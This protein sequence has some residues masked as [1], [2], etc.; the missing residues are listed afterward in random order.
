MNKQIITFLSS[1]MLLVFV[2]QQGFSQGT[3]RGTVYDDVTGETVPF[4]TVFVIETSG[5]TTTDLDGTYSYDLPAGSYTL[6]FSFIGFASLKVSE[7]EIVDDEV[8]V[9]DIRLKE[10][11]TMLDE[12][13]VTAK[14]IRNTEAAILTLQK[15]SPNLLDGISSQTFKRIGDSNV[16]GAIKRVTGV[17]VEGGK[18]VF[19]R[20]LGDRYTKSILNGMDIPGLDPD[21]NTLQMD[22]F[23]T[24]LI[25]NI[26]VVKSFT[27]DL[28]GDFTGGVVNIVTKDF[29][30]EKTMNI[31]AGLGYNP[32][33][34]LNDN[35][36]GYAGSS[37]DALGFDNGDRRRPLSRNTFIPRTAQQSPE[38]NRLTQKFS[39]NWEA[40]NKRSF[41]DYNLGFSAGNQ[42]DKKK[43]TIGYNMALNYKSTN[44][45]FD[46]V[47]YNIF[48]KPDF[49]DENAFELTPDRKQAGQLSK[50]NVLL[51]GLV[52][53]AAK[54]DN[55]KISLS[56]IRIQNGESKAGEFTR[57]TFISSDNTI[58]R[59]NLE[60]TERA[61]SNAL[62]SGK[63]SF[64]KGNLEVEWKLSP[65]Y[66]QI[67][68]KDIRLA[69]FRV[70]G[71]QFSIEPSEG[72]VPIRI[73]RSLEEVNYSGKMD[74]T[75]KILVGGNESKIKIGGSYVTKNRNYDIQNFQFDVRNADDINFSGDANDL[76]APQN[77]WT[78]E[79][80]TGVFV[81][82]NYEPA[83]TY[84]ADQNTLGAYIMNELP[85]SDKFKAVYGARVEHFQHIYTG[86]NNLGDRVFDNEE[87]INN[88]NILPA[89][90]LIYTL[91]DNMN[92]RASFSRT[93]A[94]PS[95]KEVSLAQIYDALSDRTY[96]GNLDLISTDVNNFDVRWE[97]YQTGGQMFAVSA[98]YKTFENPIEIV[99]FS[100]IAPN[101]ITPRNVG[102]A[103]VA[104]IEI[105]ARKKLSF[106]NP[107]LSF[108]TN[109][110]FVHSEVQMDRSEGGEY[111]SRVR[112]A[113]PGEI[114]KE[115]RQMQGQSPFILNSYV[116]YVLPD[117]GVEANL[118]YNVQGKRLAIVGISQNPDVFEQ[119]FH[120]LNFKFSKAVGPDQKLRLSIAGQNLL[121][122]K[123]RREYES[124][125]ADNQ[126]YES[127]APGRA[128]SISA[129]YRFF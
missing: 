129:S 113:R 100:E 52:G 71:G 88:W 112:N 78:P 22:V 19:V 24:N 111:E 4:A 75:K 36:L 54:W 76:L 94:R 57:N 11:S 31:S 37:T 66:S 89:A 29:P 114:I 53:A 41:V 106:I 62:L 72:A 21:R 20:G 34:H 84:D 83:N 42:F 77:I 80:R 15:K 87:L 60:Y 65:T 47:Q 92:L 126:T 93:L 122:S 49:D 26:V 14:Q 56:A 38:L 1:L 108:G 32:S 10:E 115:T 86:Q 81:T 124:F 51:T 45:Y 27:P 117:S 127:F 116:N 44:Q 104:G 17:S 123:I 39:N 118:S 102:D 3:V 35:A 33:M 85:I 50:N 97:N 58:N 119:P 74:V 25:D 70:D 16:A 61:I 40:Q 63:H 99:A 110:T 6:E 120:S 98:F 7:V 103:T 91:N 125:N 67:Y 82:G 59:D 73:W 13:V 43:M 18:Y 101:N 48:L 8:N 69:Q 68:D 55:H 107:G 79:S 12:I 30:E 9:L 95:F 96:I 2:C 64:D 46:D 121:G 105:E 109:L 23:P 5:G 128:M 28:P 90:N